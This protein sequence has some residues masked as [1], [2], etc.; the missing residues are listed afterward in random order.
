M[1]VLQGKKWRHRDGGFAHH[2]NKARKFSA[3]LGGRS[4]Y[5]STWS[6]CASSQQGGAFKGDDVPVTPGRSSR[7]DRQL[8]NSVSSALAH[9]HQNAHSLHVEGWV[10]RGLQGLLGL[11]EIPS[12]WREGSVCDHNF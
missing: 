1:P 12:A 8:P 3:L 10:G 9:S 6:V 11:W 4:T 5:S 7:T 2:A